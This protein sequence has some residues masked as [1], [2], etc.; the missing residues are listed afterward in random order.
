MSNNT[1]T[2]ARIVG[3]HGV[4]LGA[5]M[6]GLL[7]ARV[8]ADS[9]DRVTI[10]DRDQLPSGV[11]DRR[12]VPQG[13]QVHALLARG[14]ELLE[15]LFPGLT[16]R[17]VAD[18]AVTGDPCAVIRFVLG[19]HRLARATTGAD[20][21]FAS[22]LLLE[23][24]VRQAVRALPQVQVLDSCEALNLIT[25]G[26]AVTGVAVRRSDTGTETLAAD[27]VVDATG[28]GSR[29]PLWLS[30]M[31]CTA[32]DEDRI[33]VQV[34]YTTGRFRLRSGALD[35]DLAVLISTAPTAPRAGGLFTVEHGEVMVCL[36]GMLGDH[37]PTEPQAFLDFAATLAVPDIREALD[38]AELLE[39]L[40]PARFPANTRRRY[41]RL[42]DLPHGLIV[43]G[44]AL[45]AFN[46]IYGQGM[47]VAAIEIDV[48]RAQLRR[49]KLPPPH[50]FFR[51]AARALTPAWDL[52]TGADLQ[53]PR[54]EG[55]RPPITQVINSYVRR[56]H[57]AAVHDPALA[58]VFLQVSGLTAPPTALLRPDRLLRVLT[59]ARRRPQR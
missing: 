56:L 17:L 14:S 58:K 41:E 36:A 28:R 27:V 40:V 59:N 18:G 7:A 54:I 50:E 57:A 22:R 10:I 15:D 11:A 13:R 29:T 55:P 44:D 49:G 12:G 6:A 30:V 32:P 37:P 38:G 21:V 5:S 26:N 34:G 8:L 43:V 52:A 20:D 23:H 24:H 48:L 53:D 16:G 33:V 3:G 4:V 1:G 47:T 39:D 46:P 25:D 51:A 19:G 45:A 42:T 35:G 2:P 31:G 9:L